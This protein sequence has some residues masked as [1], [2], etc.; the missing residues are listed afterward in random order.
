MQNSVNDILYEESV[1]RFYEWAVKKDKYAVVEVIENWI[2][3]FEKKNTTPC[4][5]LY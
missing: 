2:E 3:E 5:P 1:L 4:F